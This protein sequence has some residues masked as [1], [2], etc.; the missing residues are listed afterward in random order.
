MSE[1]KWTSEAG[2]IQTKRISKGISNFKWRAKTRK[3]LTNYGEHETCSPFSAMPAEHAETLEA[4]GDEFEWT[5]TRD[6]HKAIL[7]RLLE[8][9]DAIE[10]PVDDNRETPEEIAQRERKYAEQREEQ[11]REAEKK[12]DQVK[13]LAADY[14]KKCPWAKADDGKMSSHARAAKNLKKE[15]S[16]AFPSVRFSVR[17]DSF[18]MGNSVDVKWTDGPTTKQVDAIADK[19]QYGHFNG[20]EDIYEYDHSA[21]SDAVSIVFGQSKYVHTSREFT[22]GLREKLGRALCELQQVEFQGMNTRHTFGPF[23]IDT[24]S[25]HVWRILSDNELPLGSTVVGLKRDTDKEWNYAIEFDAPTEAP[26]P[27]TTDSLGA[28]IQKHHHTKRG[29]DFFLVVPID[30]M[31]RDEFEAK[32]DACKSA[33]GWYSRKW[34]STPGGFAF[35]DE[36]DARQFAADEFQASPVTA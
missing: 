16:L 20:M 36:D 22:D 21:E 30:R 4:I 11:K 34:G 18:S 27:E 1:K 15:L 7:E 33:G 14:R 8:A 26:K 3:E 2:P 6:N 10:I 32:R 19:Y 13:R 35:K 17:S 12:A 25:T 29:F 24:L 9:T 23:D 5:I 31:K 28:E